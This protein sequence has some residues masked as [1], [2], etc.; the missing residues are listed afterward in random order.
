ML[1]VLS[2]LIGVF[3]LVGVLGEV[4]VGLVAPPTSPRRE[5]VR[6]KVLLPAL[7]PPSTS[8]CRPAD[9]FWGRG[10]GRGAGAR[11]EVKSKG[12][13]IISSV[14]G[15][16]RAARRWR[17]FSLALICLS[18]T[19]TCLSSTSTCLSSTSTCLSS[20]STCLS[21]TSTCLSSTSTCLSASVFCFFPTSSSGE[22]S[23][24]TASLTSSTRGPASGEI[25]LAP[26]LFPF[27][28]PFP[29]A[30][31][32]GSGLASLALGPSSSSLL[33]STIPRNSSTTIC[34]LLGLRRWASR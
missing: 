4:L 13:C 30:L 22:C 2:I 1:G 34:T 24:F 28:L 16:C 7:A 15:L 17:R 31:A 20:T 26:T 8:S 33:L 12:P 9:R 19:I 3:S 11:W 25:A 23:L 10:A 18:S 5:G 32:S 14:R 29:L 6:A 27:P 21:S